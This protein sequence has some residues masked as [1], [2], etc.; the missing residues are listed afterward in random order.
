VVLAF[1]HA[2]RA[3]EVLSCS[4]AHSGF[5]EVTHRLFE[6]GIFVGHDQSIWTGS[7]LRSLDCFS[8]PDEHADWEL[9]RKRGRLQGF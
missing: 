9:L 1:R 6:D 5:F 2:M 8:F 7:I 3:H 4:D